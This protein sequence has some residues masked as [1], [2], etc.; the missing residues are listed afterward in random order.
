LLP[1]S[2]A[3]G[4]AGIPKHKARESPRFFYLNLRQRNEDLT[5]K[6]E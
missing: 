4:K 6:T 1:A 3:G 2:A 5:R